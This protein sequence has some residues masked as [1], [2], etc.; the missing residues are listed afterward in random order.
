MLNEESS[1]DLTQDVYRELTVTMGPG[2]DGKA[3]IKH[4]RHTKRRKINGEGDVVVVET[5]AERVVLPE[6][7]NDDEIEVWLKETEEGRKL[8]KRYG[9][10]GDDE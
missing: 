3:S 6:P 9:W 8:L 5:V 10:E 7:M 1:V 4:G 2:V